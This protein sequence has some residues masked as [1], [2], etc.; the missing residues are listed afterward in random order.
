[1]AVKINSKPFGEVEVNEDDIIEFSDGILGF[2]FVKKFVILEEKKSPF[3]WLQACD[4]PD[5]SF[6]MISPLEFLDEY[7]LV[8]SQS[9][10][11]D[12]DAQGPE[13][14]AVFAIVTIPSH[15]PSEMTANL[16]GPVI[17][18]AAKKRGKQAISLSDKYRVRHRI[19]D[20]MN[21]RAKREG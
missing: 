8:I 9:D 20:E 17:I 13:E 3:V 4:E 10:L 14:L 19:L 7:S 21:K 6:V 15:D 12:V 2:D 5:L 11:E 1:M 16:Q 18:N